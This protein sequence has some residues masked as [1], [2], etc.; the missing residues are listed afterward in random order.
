M[1][2]RFC[3]ED[4]SIG[5][6]QSPGHFLELSQYGSIL[7]NPE[8]Y[9]E[10][11]W[12]YW[13]VPDLFKNYGSSE[14]VHPTALTLLNKD[15][16][17]SVITN[18]SWSEN[19]SRQYDP[20]NQDVKDPWLWGTSSSSNVSSLVSVTDSSIMDASSISPFIGNNQTLT[21]H[22]IQI[23]FRTITVLH[24]FWHSWR[25]AVGL[26]FTQSLVS[27]GM[28]LYIVIKHQWLRG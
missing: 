15:I 11:R 10:Y 3:A 28:R 14:Q 16:V 12:G 23:C 5:V 1:T 24:I 26:P 17:S 19:G 2:E 22:C 25:A 20:R 27:F 13:E 7:L 21:N 4:W 8:S 18:T 9:R 6:P